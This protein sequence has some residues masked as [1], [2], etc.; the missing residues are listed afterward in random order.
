MY[1]I[2]KELKQKLKELNFQC[3]DSDH[4]F[5]PD[6]QIQPCS[7]DVRLGEVF[8]KP[9]GSKPVDL[10]KSQ[11]LELAPRRYWKKFVLKEGEHLTIKPG[12]LILGR[13]YEKF[14]IPKKCAGKIEGRSS[15]SRMGLGIHICCDFINPGYRGHMPLQIVNYSKSVIKIFPYIDICQLMLIRLNGIPEKLYGV[16]ELQSKYMDD[17]G[18]PSYWWRDK[19]I[20]KLQELFA[21]KDL[22]IE[23]QENILKQ[24]G[25][26]EPEIIERFENY[27]SKCKTQD[28]SNVDT[29]LE[30]FGR[31]EEKFKTKEIILLRG[32][33][34]LPL[35]LSPV[36]IKLIFDGEVDFINII[37]WTC[38]ILLFIFFIK[39]WFYDPKEYL[40]RKKIEQKREE[41]RTAK[42]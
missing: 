28:I 18:G 6:E 17:D 14:T 27:I 5:E 21:K 10:R 35:I 26:Q 12:E 33:Q 25:V 2:D 7:I 19:R 23:I 41:I 8:W 20:K 9:K 39:S 15:F 38:N 24:I 32:V 34:I 4:K 22:S 40:T 11:L 1:L 36:S 31:K 29:V 3:H 13:I 30:K 37:I 42:M 16:N